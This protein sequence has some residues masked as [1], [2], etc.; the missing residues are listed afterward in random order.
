[1]PKTELS[2]LIY[3][4]GGW[5]KLIGL[6]F[7][8]VW[9]SAMLMFPLCKE[10]LI[11]YVP[12]VCGSVFG[13]LMCRPKVRKKLSAQLISAKSRNFW[14]WIILASFV[15]RLLTLFIWAKYPAS[16]AGF[17]HGKATDILAG[18]GYGSTAFLPPGWPYLLSGWY[19]LTA[20]RPLF[21]YLLGILLSTG[22][23]LII[24]DI[25]RRVLSPLA[26]RWAALLTAI[27]PTLVFTA[28]RTDTSSVLL[29][30]VLAV[31]DLMLISRASGSKAWLAVLSIGVLLGIGSLIKPVLLIAPLI[32]TICWLSWRM[33][34]TAFF[35][36]AVCIFSMGCFITPWTIR[37]YRV[38]GSFVL[39]STNGGY[40]LY[41]GSNPQSNGMWSKMKPPQVETETDQ[42]KIAR[43]YRDAALKWIKENPLAWCKLALKKQVYMWGTSSTSI[44][45]N[46]NND[47]PPPIRSALSAAIKAVINTFWA[48]LCVLVVQG[49][50]RT[51]VW[52]N[53]LLW[54]LLLMLLCVFAVHLVFEVMSRYHIPVIG[55][56]IL[57]ASAGLADIGKEPAEEIAKIKHE[58]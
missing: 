28:A 32:M 25:A 31:A 13:Y 45:V 51:K 35:Y 55:A 49:T 40:V 22:S 24:Y 54:P 36:A 23:V 2:K 15:L 4:P 5:Q 46:I 33:G 30:I 7:C 6:S 37:N 11:G 47:I 12:I 16:D 57:I 1:M 21:G 42:V 34:R 19:W 58:V 3:S 29:F 8:L 26:A 52:Q 14:I 43:I 44:A 48:L 50:L 10:Q 9:V 27:M 53:Q 20:P 38:L 41:H 17:Y 18:K 56:L 39:V